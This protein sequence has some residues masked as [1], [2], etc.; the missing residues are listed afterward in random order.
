MALRNDARSHGDG[1]M[2]RRESE[3]TCADLERK[4]LFAGRL[5]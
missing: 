2:T 4:W 5:Q 1:A 3:I